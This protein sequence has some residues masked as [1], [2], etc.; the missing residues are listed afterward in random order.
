V[1]LRIDGASEI[2][3]L[4][5]DGTRFRFERGLGLKP[6]TRFSATGFTD[7][8]PAGPYPTMEITAAAF[9]SRPAA[10]D[11]DQDGNLLDDEWERFFFGETGQDPYSQPHGD[12]Y[13]LLQYFLAGVDPRGGGSPPGPPI[14][15]GPQLPIL[16]PVAGGAYHLDFLFPAGYQD[17]FDFVLERS[18]TL[19]PGS[20]LPIPGID[21]SSLGGDELRAVIPPDEAPAGTAFYRI[22][23]VLD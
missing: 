9:V 20:W 2:A 11:N 17:L 21:I 15:L 23:V 19:A 12:G 10:S 3:L 6:G 22:R 14:D 18:T 13:S 5:A 1:Y 16:T 4:N 7:T 8:P